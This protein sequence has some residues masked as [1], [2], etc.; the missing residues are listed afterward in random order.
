MA[1]TPFIRD[2]IQALAATKRVTR[3]IPSPQQD[4]GSLYQTVVALQQA[5]EQ[6]TR[7][8]GNSKDSALLLGEV[9]PLVKAIVFMVGGDLS[10][11][12]DGGDAGVAHSSLGGLN[13]NDHPQYVLAIQLGEL[14][15]ATFSRYLTRAQYDVREAFNTAAGRGYK[16]FTYS[17]GLVTRVDIWQSADKTNKLFTKLLSYVG[18]QVTQVVTTDEQTEMVLTKNL[19][20]SGI[21]VAT[22]TEVLS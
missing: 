6:L 14:L 11:G 10:G 12:N 19:T 5:V 4:I 1:N 18:S 17:G 9:E 2:L 13:Q 8:R 16:E 3:G 7:S 21:E 15:A 22:L 20:Y